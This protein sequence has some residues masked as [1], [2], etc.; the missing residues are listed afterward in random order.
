MFQPF[1]V[2]ETTIRYTAAVEHRALDPRGPPAGLPAPVQDL[3]GGGGRER[4]QARPRAR[5]WAPS[6]P[7]TSARPRRE[8]VALLRDTNYA[9]FQHYFGGFG[10]WEAFRTPGG[11]R[12]VPARPV[13][14]PA[15]DGVD[16][17]P[18][19]Q[20]EVR[21]GRDTVT[22]SRRD[23]GAAERSAAAAT[24]SGSAGSSIRA[25]CPG[26]RRC[27]RS[28]S[29]PSTSSRR[30]GNYFEAGLRCSALG[31]EPC[32]RGGWV[33]PVALPTRNRRPSK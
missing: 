24:S 10:F 14:A 4:A 17:R 29:S 22:R 28:S 20:G 9:G 32:R 6:G 5:A 30:S 33:P 31:A 11:R 15:A 26:R 7:S 19:A 3:P 27:A 13:H 23:R 21:A 16:G 12:Q 25:S 1:S 8:A 2:S 18:D